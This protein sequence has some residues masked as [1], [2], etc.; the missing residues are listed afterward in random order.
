MSLRLFGS[1]LAVCGALI[2]QAAPAAAQKHYGPGV[3]DT[4][5]KIG[6]TMA[7]S[8]PASGLSEIGKTEAAYF[9]ML[10]DQGGVNGRKITFISYDDAYTP[11]KTIEMVRK[12]VESDQVLAIFDSLGTATNTAIAPYLNREKIPQLFISSG[13]TKFADPKTYPWTMGW[14]TNY[15][16]E[17]RV[18]AA[19]ILQS[20]P[21]AKIAVLYQNDD[22]GKDLLAGIK[23]RLGDQAARMLVASASYE[24]TDATVDSQIVSLQASGADTFVIVATPK[25]GSLAIRKAGEIGWQR[26]VTVT[27]S[28][29]NSIDAVLRPAGLD[30]ALGLVTSVFVKD[31]SDP[32]WR[33]DAALKAWAA[34][35]DRYNPAGDKTN[36]LNLVAYAEAIT[37]AQVLRQCGDDL[38]RENV[39]RQATNLKN[40][41]IGVLLPGIT[42]NT[43]PTDYSPIK[44]LQMA[45]FDGTRWQ[46]F[47][48]IIDSK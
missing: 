26:K 10:N 34:F 16:S 25:F 48:P 8:G 31:P 18:Y 22:F 40:F 38:T 37:M 13:A 11:A 2:A 33:D 15:L 5:I 28:G 14:I 39:M 24:I 42:V 12:L 30:N 17:G 9:K 47:G 45:R 7:Y 46:L 32:T 41:A 35:M 27:Q 20:H 44:Q 21:D 43:S 19:Y 4:E 29:T 36:P 23:D 1:L 6:N 3:S